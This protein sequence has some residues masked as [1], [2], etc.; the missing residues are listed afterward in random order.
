MERG[1]K[2]DRVPVDLV[3]RREFDYILQII[4]PTKVDRPS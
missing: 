4:D 3:G 2:E 1:D